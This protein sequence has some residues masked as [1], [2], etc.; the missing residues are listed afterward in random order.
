VEA[1][2]SVAGVTRRKSFAPRVIVNP[3]RIYL[4]PDDLVIKRTLDGG[5]VCVGFG[6]G[7]RFLHA[8]ESDHRFNNAIDLKEAEVVATPDHPLANNDRYLRRLGIALSIAR[9]GGYD[10]NEPRDEHGRRT[11]EGLAALSLFDANLGSKV[12]GA[13][14]MLASR[15]NAAETLLNIILVPTNKSLISDGAVPDA[16]GITY[17]FDR[18]T[19]RLTLTQENDDGTSSVIYSDRYGADGLF[20]DDDGN[21]IGR[22]LGDGVMLDAGQIPG[23]QYQSDND[24]KPEVCPDPGP[25]EPGWP[26]HSS[27][28]LAYQSQIS[29]LP[30]GLAINFNGVSFD[31]CRLDNGDLL[32]AKGEGFVWA[33]VDPNNW[34]AYYRGVADAMDQANKQNK[35]LEGTDRIVE[36]HFAEEQVGNYFREEFRKAGYDHIVVINTPLRK[37]FEIE[38]LMVLT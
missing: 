29:G 34:A 31:G 11:S 13:L 26:E 23:H 15:P 27:R 1:G 38:G 2:D 37:L 20:R 12:L 28:S 32:E 35:A 24:S 22:H 8:V 5:Y 25:D 17:H 9:A 33:M 18:G 36:W 6:G 7:A 3:E 16:P 30:P 19:G 10:P 4:E 14:R 21:V